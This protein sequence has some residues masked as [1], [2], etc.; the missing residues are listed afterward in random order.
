MMRPP[1]VQVDG[2][3]ERQS[4]DGE[5]SHGDFVA[6]HCLRS[7]RAELR[8]R[9]NELHAATPGP[10]H[11]EP[12]LLVPLVDEQQALPAVRLHHAESVKVGA[13]EAGLHELV[14]W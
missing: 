3:R 10:R 1:W 9:V 11:D 4:C 14:T 12:R 7:G 8:G 13:L 6:A 5:P 2:L